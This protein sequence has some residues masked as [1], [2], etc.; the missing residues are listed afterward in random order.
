MR[1]KLEQIMSVEKAR[2]EKVSLQND[3]E[4]KIVGASFL[5]ADPTPRA[6]KLCPGQGRVYDS[7]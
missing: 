3:L 4:E 5:M 2:G 6:T 1:N 7:I